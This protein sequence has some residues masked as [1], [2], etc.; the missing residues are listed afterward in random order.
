MADSGS[1]LS[2]AGMMR[3]SS[4]DLVDG[5]GR[6]DTAAP[7]HRRRRTGRELAGAVP[8]QYRSSAAKERRPRATRRVHHRDHSSAASRACPSTSPSHRFTG[9]SGDVRRRPAAD[10]FVGRR[11]RASQ[12]VD[13]NGPPPA[14][15][16]R[17]CSVPGR[18]PPLQR[19]QPPPARSCAE[20]PAR[21]PVF[22]ST[23]LRNA[24]VFRG[25]RH[26]PVPPRRSKRET[27]ERVSSDSARSGRGNDRTCAPLAGSEP[28][29]SPAPRTARTTS[30]SRTPD[31]RPL[32]PRA[33]H[34]GHVGPRPPS[35]RHRP[36]PRRLRPGPGP[37]PGSRS[38]RH[39]PRNRPRRHHAHGPGNS[40]P[41][42]P[43]GRR[44]A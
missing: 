40:R 34:V 38:G 14:D 6:P 19:V 22:S 20:R 16:P 31:R 35:P 7:V 13:T 2:A 17:R 44:A 12:P 28:A 39:H 8:R 43:A 21:A 18:A 27:T 26:G 23:V 5:C 41:L 15:S 24:L 25:L 36:R 30:A 32:R 42:L 1:W 37:G 33:G 3:T 29:S 4:D 11:S 10:D 9:A